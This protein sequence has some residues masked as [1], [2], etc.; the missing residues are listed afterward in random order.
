M[1]D[2]LRLKPYF[3]RHRA[4]FLLGMLFVTLSNV[5]STTYPRIAAATINNIDRSIKAHTFSGTDVARNIG[6]ILLLTAGSGFFMYLTRRTII[7][8][9]RLIEFELRSD[10]LRALERLPLRYF[11]Q[12]PTGELMAYSTNDISATREFIGP[13]VMYTANT[14]T[15][16][17]FVVTMMLIINP[18]ITFYAL[19]PLPL[20]SFAVYKLGGKVHIMF[21]DAQDHYAKMTA[22]AQENLSGVR[23]IRAYTRE[24]HEVE[25]WRG[26]SKGYLKKMMGLVRFEAVTMPL[27][28]CLIGISQLMVLGAGG[29][30]VMQGSFTIGE[31]T[32]FFI[33][34]N[35]LIWP[36]VAVG[37]VTNLIQRASASMGRLGRIFDEVPDIADNDRTDRSMTAL[38]GAIEFRNVKLQYKLGTQASTEKENTPAALK[39][40]YSLGS[41]AESL[42][43][44]IRAGE[45]IG[46][47]GETGAGKSSFVNVIP[48]LFDVSEG[49]ILL[50][51]RDIREIPLSLVRH[52][53]AIVPQESFLFSESI[54][55]N[56]RF[57]KPNA[58]M[59]EVVEASIAAQL[60]D[61]VKSF[62][63]GYNTIT[64]ERGVTLSGGQKQRTAI[65]RAVIRK[66]SI[67]IFDD[68]L[69][70]VDTE[71]EEHVLQ[72]LKS[73]MAGR[74]SMFIAH[75]ISTVKHADRI[76]V[77]HKGC[78]A[79]LGTHDELLERGGIYAEMYH[80][81]LLED[82]ISAFD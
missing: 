70:A 12:T 37:W 23:V 81:Q 55:N 38:A 5:C 69:S 31:L 24:D 79:E 6:W 72:N 65:A 74:T 80:R 8:A 45:T 11:Q 35:Q 77:L 76:V 57:G 34:L 43:L 66:P 7:V 47:V 28:I 20:V 68:A 59:D 64:G 1:N 44:T 56:I 62:P 52:S 61:N 30:F 22:V 32:Q 73:V 50:D 15:T 71:T 27:M 2:L 46:I 36:V 21:K 58:S 40:P 26:M 4:K 42:S 14:I 18:V 67:L 78:I 48:R 19:L 33:Y 10:V 16:F 29:Y 60:H 82:E 39:A 51:G 53:I 75:R 54:A 17:L 9:S 41:A 25:R 63:D 3:Q 13:A 49:A